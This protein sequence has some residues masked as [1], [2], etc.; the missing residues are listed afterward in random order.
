MKLTI[1]VLIAVVAL[2]ALGLVGCCFRSKEAKLTLKNRPKG[3]ILIVY[4][5]QSKTKNTKTVAGWIQQQVGGDLLE[6]QRVKPYSDSYSTTLKEAKADLD[7]QNPP[8]I[9]PL[10]KNVADYDMVFVG[11]PIW[12]GTF[13]PPVKTFLAQAALN[14]KTVIPFCTHG[15]GG[16]SRFFD[17]VKAALPNSTL[18]EGIAMRGTNVVERTIGYGTE[19]RESPDTITQWLDKI[20]AEQNQ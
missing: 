11:S 15:G 8:E 19:Y 12:Y 2:S 7:A 13:A 6:I 14:G 16:P 10:D 18:L 3:K 1:I 4:F 20:L 9:L 5:S 17:D